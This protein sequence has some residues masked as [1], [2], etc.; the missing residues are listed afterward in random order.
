M[1]VVPGPRSAPYQKLKLSQRRQES[2]WLRRPLMIFVFGMSTSEIY[3][4][5]CWQV[6]LSRIGMPNDPTLAKLDT[7]F[8]SQIQPLPH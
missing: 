3:T 5:L 1:C 8:F 6:S 7:F 4:S 2:G